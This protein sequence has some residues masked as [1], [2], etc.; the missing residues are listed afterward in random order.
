MAKT[1]SVGGPI[2]VGAVLSPAESQYAHLSNGN[3][4]TCLALGKQEGEVCSHPD[5]ETL[6]WPSALI[7]GGFWETQTGCEG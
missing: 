5:L 2:G 6:S 1:L 4:T 7:Q 3:E